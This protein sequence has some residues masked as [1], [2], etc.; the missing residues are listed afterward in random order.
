MEKFKYIIAIIIIFGVVIACNRSRDKDEDKDK[1]RSE[2][3]EKYSKDKD[4]D[5]DAEEVEMKII[6]GNPYLLENSPYVMIPVRLVRSDE[7]IIGKLK[8][9]IFSSDNRYVPLTDYFTSFDYKNMYNIIYYN[10]SDSSVYSLL[11]R[12]ALINKFYIPSQKDADTSRG[13]FIIFTLIEEDYNNDND[14]DDDDG[15]TV[16]KCSL[17]GQDIRQISPDRIRLIDWKSSDANDRIYLYI[18]EDSNRDM[19]FN[20]D[21]RT[22]IIGTSISNS[23]I[24]VEIIADSLKNSMNSLYL[25]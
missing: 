24:G 23:S 4:D 14:I 3:V 17:Y 7:D 25:K 16:Y 19:M 6:Y 20:S 5:E 12:K 8:R 18:T 15:E 11:N 1:D 10:S 2:K 21:D 22:K 9:E 13:N